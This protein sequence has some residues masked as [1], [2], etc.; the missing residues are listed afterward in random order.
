VVTRHPAP[1]SSV[2]PTIPLFIL[3]VTILLMVV[4]FTFPLP[5]AAQGKSPEVDVNLDTPSEVADISTGIAALVPVNGNISY[6]GTINTLAIDVLACGDWETHVSP[7]LIAASGKTV[8]SFAGT[9]TVPQSSDGGTCD[10]RVL[11]TIEGTAIYPAPTKS[12]T[13]N[14]EVV[15]ERFRIT[16]LGA[17][18]MGPH[19]EYI[20]RTDQNLTSPVDVPIEFYVHNDGLTDDSLLPSFT[21]ETGLA[22]VGWLARLLDLDDDDIPIPARSFVN[23]TYIVTIPPTAEPGNYTFSLKV[24]SSKTD[25]V[26]GT[27]VLVVVNPV[28]TPTP[29]G[30][31][32]DGEGGANTILGMPLYLF[33]MVVSLTVV[34]ICMVVVVSG[35]EVGFFAFL[36]WVVVPLYVRVL[37]EKVLDNFTR[38][39]IFGF[40][41]AN[42]GAH[43]GEIRNNM[44]LQNGVLAYHLLV[45][46]REGYVKTSRDGMFKRFYPRSMRIPRKKKHLSRMQKDIV[47]AV[48]KTPGMNQNAIAREL[49]ESKQ[50]ISYHV[51]ALAKADIIVVQKAGNETM[52]FL[53][54]HVEGAEGSEDTEE[55]E[56]V[57][58]EGGAIGTPSG[59]SKAE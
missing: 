10:V 25:S 57:E 32:S 24:M 44:S 11:V 5:A 15:K 35:T 2:D 54:E 56:L 39:Q 37:K 46:E 21:L 38:G 52:C 12:A 8:Y 18:G 16:A 31:G 53:A 55:V 20:F 9:I 42:P 1:V 6:D 4:L 59:G 48:R 22:E 30:G 36:A 50:V 17:A 41:K 19:G 45:L 27:D 29:G 26:A 7:E 43:Y 14:L 33:L 47:E 28:N 51:K 23:M 58:E 13:L 49:G 3:W 40:I 34:G